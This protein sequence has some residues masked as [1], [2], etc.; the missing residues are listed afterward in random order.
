M[1]TEHTLIYPCK[2]GEVFLKL[3]LVLPHR[4]LEAAHRPYPIR[5]SL[6][7]SFLKRNEKQLQNDGPPIRTQ[8]LYPLYHLSLHR[9]LSPPV[10]NKYGCRETLK[11]KS[12]KYHKLVLLLRPVGKNSD[13]YAKNE[14]LEKYSRHPTRS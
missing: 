6:R 13:G 3:P 9:P 8:S 11:Q 2:L 10:Q 1:H 4:S 14:P 5:L 7:C 12:R